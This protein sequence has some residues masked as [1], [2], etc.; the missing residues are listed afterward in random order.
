MIGR[1]GERDRLWEMMKD[2]VSSGQAKAIVLGGRAGEGKTRLAQWLSWRS[3]ELGL[4][5]TIKVTALAKSEPI[6]AIQTMVESLLH[7]HELDQ[8][9]K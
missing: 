7:V 2:C 8:K 4:A 9:E 6:S 1:E 3:Q 5:R